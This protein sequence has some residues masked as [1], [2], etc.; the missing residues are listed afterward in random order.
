MLPPRLKGGR[1][2]RGV[3][4]PTIKS[5]TRICSAFFILPSLK[6]EQLPILFVDWHSN[7]LFPSKNQYYFKSPTVY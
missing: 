2:A 5:R 3:T 7:F 1:H 4:T 6:K